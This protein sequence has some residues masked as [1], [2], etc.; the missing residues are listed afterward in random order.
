VLHT[1]G[2]KG[3]TTAA[4]IRKYHVE[5]NKWRDIGYH[6]VVRKNGEVEFGRALWT[7]GAHTEGAN[8]TIGICVTGD[9]DSEAWTAA[10]REAVLVT[11]VGLCNTHKLTAEDV[12]GHREAPARLRAKPT[13]KTCPGKLV[14]LNEVR[15]ALATRLAVSQWR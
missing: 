12:C 2:V 15:A 10:Q 3:D 1:V 5:H 11:V 14:D 9:G 4:A 8:D 6:L 7:T 13:T